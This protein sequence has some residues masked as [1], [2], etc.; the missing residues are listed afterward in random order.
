MGLSV[1]LFFLVS[2]ENC[3]TERLGLKGGYVNEIFA[4]EFVFTPHFKIL[5]IYPCI[6]VLTIFQ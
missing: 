6:V 5:L 3:L 4:K 2:L 1:A